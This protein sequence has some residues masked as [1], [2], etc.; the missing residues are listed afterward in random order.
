MTLSP[1]FELHATCQ[2]L[3]P[4]RLCPVGGETRCAEVMALNEEWKLR[5]ENV[6]PEW[7]N[8]FL[9]S[10]LTVGWE[11]SGKRCYSASVRVGLKKRNNRQHHY[12]HGACIFNVARQVSRLEAGPIISWWISDAGEQ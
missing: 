11:V 2:S 6:Q 12:N 4:G 8:E 7:L 10:S 1:D 3:E 9:S 5:F